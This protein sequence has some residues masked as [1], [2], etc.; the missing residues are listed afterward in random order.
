MGASSRPTNQVKPFA[1][2]FEGRF[3]MRL[4]AARALRPFPVIGRR[5]GR[6]QEVLRL[7]SPDGNMLSQPSLPPKKKR[8]HVQLVCGDSA[9]QGRQPVFIVTINCRLWEFSL[10]L[11]QDEFKKYM[12][13][14][15]IAVAVIE[16][17][18]T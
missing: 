10:P 16:V 11:R 12:D 7:S 3:F 15:E 18:V 8:G 6:A 4:D 14:R 17:F 9:R 13:E 1:T 5:A 2:A